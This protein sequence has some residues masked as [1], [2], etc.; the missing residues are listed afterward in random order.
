MSQNK[1][2]VDLLNGPIFKG[3]VVFALPILFSTVFQQLYNTVDT[4]IVGNTL[5]DNSLAA[6]GA[7]T[8]IYDLMVGF[9]L[10]IGNG[11]AIVTARSYGSKDENLL[12]KSVASALV[13]GVITSLVIT[14]IGQYTLLPLLRVLNTPEAIV[15]ESLS[16]IKT[17]VL[18]TFVMFMYNLCAGLL[19][20]VGNSLMPLIF[21]VVSSCLNIGLDYYFITQ[22]N[23]GVRGAA[24]ATVISQGVS[25]VCCLYY[26]FKNVKLLVPEKE[27]FTI[28]V[29]LYKEML[30]QGLSMGFMG[31]IV[32]AGSVILQYGINGLGTLVIAGHTAARK[33]Y[34][35][36]NMPFIAMGQAMST[37]VSQNKGANQRDRIRQGLRI[38]YTYDVIM[39]AIITGIIFLTAKPLVQLITGSSE[40]VVIDNAV[41]YLK[42]VG[43][44][45]AVLGV[46]IQSRFALQGI[47]AKIVPLISSVIELVGKILFVIIFI[48]SF[49]Y[50]A[51]IFCEPVIWCVMTLQLLLSLWTHPY[52]KGVE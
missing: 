36:F 35:F 19:R 41:M 16:Y 50:M 20:A 49:Q 42:V 45:Y 39:A 22:L 15:M 10:G 31:S 29:N 26:I 28:D 18:F 12:K 23:M 3:L 1:N 7:C 13:I 47:G 46:L 30:G 52:M 17:I 37:F 43:P 33:I 44:F 24:V 5:G 25:V 4:M 27:H 38:G 48:P 9:A 21:L 2:R 8:A 32:S 34:M 51:V 14:V 11:L 40:A 6:I